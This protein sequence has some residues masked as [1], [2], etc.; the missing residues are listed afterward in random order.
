MP[1]VVS[2]ASRI[3]VRLKLAREA[4][5]LTQLDAMVAIRQAGHPKLSVSTLQRWE[6]TGA[7]SFEDA[8]LMARIYGT[9]LD[10]MAGLP[11][12]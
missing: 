12:R 11:S 2:G 6:R 1:P 4:A 10:E 5:G 3:G 7:I 8:I 9:T